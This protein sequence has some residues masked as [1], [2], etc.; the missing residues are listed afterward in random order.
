MGSRR[1]SPE[2][3]R[4]REAP[5]QD[6]A[7]MQGTNDVKTPGA[8]APDAGNVQNLV[9]GTLYTIVLVRPANC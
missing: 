4:R 8:G 7:L 6:E 1:Q 3:G 9:Q 2:T 5:M